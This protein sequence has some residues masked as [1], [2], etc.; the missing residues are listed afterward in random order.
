[1]LWTLFSSF[2]YAEQIVILDNEKSRNAA[3]EELVDSNAEFILWS[4]LQKRPLSFANV[5]ERQICLGKVVSLSELEE[6]LQKADIGILYFEIDKAIGH[7]RR[8]END[9]VCL[10]EKAPSSLLS[11]TQYLL[12]VS[13]FYDEKYELA[14]DSWKQALLFDPNLEWDPNIEPS[15]KSAFRETKEEIQS[16]A[17]SRLI[18][19]PENAQITIDGYPAQNSMNIDAGTHLVQ[20]DKL[21]HQGNVIKT[22]VGTDVITVSFADFPSDLGELMADE[23]AR[24]E[25]LSGLRI[26]EQQSDI[27]V[28]AND[29][30]WS[31]SFGI[32]QWK[33]TSFQQ[34][35]IRIQPNVSLLAAGAGSLLIGGGAMWLA[36]NK[37][38]QYM[39]VS[40]DQADSIYLTNRVAW[41]SGTSL[42]TVGG[43]L[44]FM[45]TFAF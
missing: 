2:A 44:L 39:E 8:I 24:N 28:V 6:S 15:G 34:S 36:Q 5:E 42:L 1:M 21:N 13:Y 10:N 14:N 9:M 12:G 37:H 23:D 29:Q 43:G 41:F 18:L 40:D 32:N 4:D 31:T 26:T 17:L 45:G 25:L 35:F 19:V 3:L 27:R 16:Q 38:D 30:L 33:S 11:K 22:T 7:I 20:H